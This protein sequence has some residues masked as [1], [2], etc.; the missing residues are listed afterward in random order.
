[1]KNTFA[2]VLHSQSSSILHCMHQEISKGGNK[3][4]TKTIF[5]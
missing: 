2:L 3:D 1:M 5:L 4:L